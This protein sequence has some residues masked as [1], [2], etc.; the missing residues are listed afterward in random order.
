MES[1]KDADYTGDY[2]GYYG[3]AAWFP[4][5]RTLIDPQS[6]LKEA[7]SELLADKEILGKKISKEERDELAEEIRRLV[8]CCEQ[9][10]TNIKANFASLAPVLKKLG[11]KLSDIPGK[12]KGDYFIVTEK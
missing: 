6:T 9:T 7:V 12:R 2:S 5:A 10:G 8:R 11:Y 3:L 1:F 4:D